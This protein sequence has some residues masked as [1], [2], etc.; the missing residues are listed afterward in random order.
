MLR[1]TMQGGHSGNHTTALAMT[2]E[3][4][5]ANCR[6]W[7]VDMQTATRA[8]TIEAR[9]AGR[10]VRWFWQAGKQTSTQTQRLRLEVRGKPY[11]SSAQQ[12]PRLGTGTAKAE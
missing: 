10:L 6:V 2:L 8:P 12:R 7:H 5:T 3:A 9:D 1:P 11:R 4:G